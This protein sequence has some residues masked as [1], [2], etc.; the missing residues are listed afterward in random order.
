MSFSWEETDLVGKLWPQPWLEY[1]IYPAWTNVRGPS[2]LGSG[3][4]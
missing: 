2:A 1:V 3:L 4:L